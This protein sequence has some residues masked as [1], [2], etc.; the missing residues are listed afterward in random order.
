VYSVF[1]VIIFGR[2][3]DREFEQPFGGKRGFA[4]RA[5]SKH[6]FVCRFQAKEELE[7]LLV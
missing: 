2:S 6:S 5:V 3:I 1:V 7:M 4:P